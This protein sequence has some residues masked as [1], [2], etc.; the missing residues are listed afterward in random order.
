MMVNGRHPEN[1]F[2]GELE[3]RHL[4]DDRERL[5]HENPADDQQK[6]L[7]LGANGDHPEHP[8]DRERAGIA[9]ENAGWI[10]VKPKEPHASPHERHAKHGQ[11][12]RLRVIGNLQVFGDADMPCRIGDERIGKSCG[13]RAT[14]RQSIE[15]VGEVHR[16]GGSHDHQ[17]EEEEG[18]HAEI[19]NE[20]AFIEWHKEFFRLDLQRGAQH[21]KR[22]HNPR[23]RKLREQFHPPRQTVGFLLRHFDIVVDE[24]DDT[25]PKHGEEGEPDKRVIGPRPKQRGRRHGPE[26]QD[27]A[28]RGRAALAAVQLGQ[29]VHLFLG[30]NRLADF[31]PD[32]F[33]DHP[34]SENQAEQER[35]HRGA[36]RTERDVSKHVG[37]VDLLA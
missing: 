37:S 34:V 17:G 15:T 23:Q 20:R 19:L 10:G 25:Q 30:A 24:S 5:D 21:K 31:Q 2:A 33:S 8:A 22:G 35:G 14:S 32:Q 18:E 13:D 11:L 9:H 7:L 28:H 36:N 3:A 12:A 29:F 4:Q 27:A 16:V 6:K 26:D 1:P